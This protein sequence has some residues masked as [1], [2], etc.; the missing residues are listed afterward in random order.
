MATI[1]K[2]PHSAMPHQRHADWLELFFDLVFVALAAQLAHSL[3]G[4]PSLRDFAIM[5]ALY[6]PP[7][8]MWI[9][10]TVSANLFEDD[11]ARRRLVLLSAMACLAVMAAAI[12][13]VAGERGPLYALGYAGT[14]FV[15]LGL[16]W[17]ATRLSAPVR[18]PKWRPLSYCLVSGVLWVVSAFTPEPWRYGLWALL[19]VAE[20]LL[21]IS[22]RGL[23]GQLHKKHLVERVGLFV[24]I[25]LG[26]SVLTLITSTDHAWSAR[27]GLTALL[28]FVLLAALWWSYFDAGVALAEQ[29]LD[30]A[31]ERQA[32]LL[33]RDTAGFL[34]FFVTASVICI[35]GGLAT[36]VHE[37]G[38]DHLPDGA[39]IALAGGLAMYY[40][41]LA[42]IALR[43]RGPARRVVMWAVPSVG[44]PVLV[45]LFA[46][47][48]SPWLVVLILAAEAI[49]H[50]LYAKAR[51]R[52]RPAAGMP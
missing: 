28:G 42:C 41:T 12:P 51:A 49:V 9:N 17:P 33:V 35:A 36:T 23:P 3:H 18:V 37:A 16:W 32:F 8:W 10:F 2:A 22:V 7:W 48:L 34:H 21:L 24:I 5:L 45:L 47:Y 26:E 40:C 29:T 52:Q 11:G 46:Q 27:A 15:L 14:R 25:V 38:H 4:D 20:V 50:V 44:I 43:Y 6:F 30:A 13:D 1:S 19:I 31:Q 39:I